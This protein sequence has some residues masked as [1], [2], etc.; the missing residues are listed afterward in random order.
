[1]PTATQLAHHRQLRSTSLCGR[2]FCSQGS[3]QTM[4]HT[5]SEPLDAADLH[6]LSPLR[7]IPSQAPHGAPEQGCRQSFAHSFILLWLLRVSQD[8]L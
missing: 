1:M 6:M 4:C 7:L 5:S 3:G 8:A 2:E